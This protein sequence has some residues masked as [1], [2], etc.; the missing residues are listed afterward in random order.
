MFQFLGNDTEFPYLT[1]E[2]LSHIASHNIPGPMVDKIILEYLKLPMTTLSQVKESEHDV[3]K[4]LMECLVR[5]RNM[6][7][8]ND[9]DARTLLH[10]LLEQCILAEEIG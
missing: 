7:E 2:Q 4:T 3:Y 5:W 6:K 10:A 1:D 9:E 8:C